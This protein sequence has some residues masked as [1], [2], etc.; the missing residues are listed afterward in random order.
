M[1]L[2]LVF[3]ELAQLQLLARH[4]TRRGNATEI[5]FGA[6]VAAAIAALPGTEFLSGKIAQGLNDTTAETIGTTRILAAA[7]R[8]VTGAALAGDADELVARERH[9]L[10]DDLGGLN[11]GTRGNLGVP[12]FV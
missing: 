12:R 6:A 11:A 4:R 8:A 5:F 7:F 9:T 3:F 10:F 1:S 2:T